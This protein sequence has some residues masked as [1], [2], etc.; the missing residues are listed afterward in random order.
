[1]G[2][3]IET[4]YWF[5]FS[6]LYTSNAKVIETHESRLST[7]Q[8]FAYRIN[9]IFCSVYNNSV[10]N[11]VH[12]RGWWRDTYHT[13]SVFF[14]LLVFDVVSYILYINIKSAVKSEKWCNRLKKKWIFNKML[15]FHL[16]D[17]NL[18]VIVINIWKIHNRFL[19]TRFMTSYY[20]YYFLLTRL[21][22]KRWNKSRHYLDLIRSW[23]F[24]FTHKNHKSPLKIKFK[25]LDDFIRRNLNWS[26]TR[27]MSII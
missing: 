19:L 23:N 24:F 12:W 9:T 14:F 17:H 20:C 18:F 15:I 5:F 21:K 13:P 22:F 1:M 4:N 7:V 6:E 16:A 10:N 3:Q 11:F 25:M 2:E 8:Y 26:T 27:I